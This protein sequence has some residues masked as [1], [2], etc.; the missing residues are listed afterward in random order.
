MTKPNFYDCQECSHWDDVN[1]CWQD[2]KSVCCAGM[3]D[4]DGLIIEDEKGG[5]EE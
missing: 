2:C 4:E 5:D 3:L 1:G